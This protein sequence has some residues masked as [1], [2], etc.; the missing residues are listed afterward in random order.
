MQ[1]N[2]N[3]KFLI[4]A[5]IVAGWDKECGGAVYACPIGGTMVPEKWT[6]D[7]SGSTYIW[8]YMDA[9]FREDFTQQEAEEFVKEALALAM[10]R[11]GSSGGIMRLV[12]V[13]EAGSKQQYI[14]GPDVP[15]FGDELPCVQPPDSTGVVV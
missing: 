4:G 1:M 5:T 2:F 14:Q 12:T 11:D 8:G 6:T 3:N 10:S 13:T 9:A 7:G 15:L